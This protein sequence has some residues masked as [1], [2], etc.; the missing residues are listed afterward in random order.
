M[1]QNGNRREGFNPNR[2]R[3]LY[4]LNIIAMCLVTI[5]MVLATGYFLYQN[6]QLTREVNRLENE[7]NELAGADKT[8]YTKDEI[9]A[10]VAEAEEKKETST[11]QD[12]L[13]QIRSSLENGSSTTATLRGLFTEEVIVSNS[14]QYYFYPI[15]NSVKKNGFKSGDFQVSDSGRLSYVGGSPGVSVRMGIDVVDKAESID[16]ALAQED[17]ITFAMIKLGG[18]DADGQLLLLDNV[19]QYLTESSDSGMDVGV[20]YDFGALTREEAASQASAVVEA[21]EPYRDRI[22]FPVGISIS[23]PTEGSDAAN[24]TKRERTHMLIQA[25]DVITEAGY[26]PILYGN[27]TGLIMLTD[28]DM[29]NDYA[30]WLSDTSGSVYYPYDFTMWQYSEGLEVQGI[31]GSVGMDLYIKRSSL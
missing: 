6:R 12:I 25:M 7:M 19:D 13:M 28:L 23:M 26:T 9:D 20:V 1:N 24:L 10:A 2:L 8:L 27:M 15:L 17:G 4:Y 18:F 21:L 14:G 30:K 31:E 5:A 22:T 29:L 11:R 16:W 3:S